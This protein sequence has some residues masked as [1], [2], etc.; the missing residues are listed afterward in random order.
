MGEDNV[1]EKQNRK[2]GNNHAPL[3]AVECRNQ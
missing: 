1:N 3:K 2:S